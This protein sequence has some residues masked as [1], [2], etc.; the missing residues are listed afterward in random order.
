MFAAP[1]IGHFLTTGNGP[2]D[3]VVHNNEESSVSAS[4]PPHIATALEAVKR[5]LG[6]TTNQIPH[7]LAQS[8]S[9]DIASAITRHR[10]S[11][12][13]VNS[14]HSLDLEAPDIERVT[15][16]ALAHTHAA[17]Q[18]VGHTI[19]VVGI[20]EAAAIDFL[21]I[22]GIALGA[23]S[24]TPAGRGAGDVDVLV[25]PRDVPRVH[26]VLR[27]HDFRP[28]LAL[29]DVTKPRTWRVWSF[30]DREA[31][32][33]G[34]SA[35]IDLHWRISSQ[36]HLFPPFND[37]FARRTRV[38][39]AG[40]QVPTLSLAD[41]LAAAC[42]H[43]YFD[44]FQ[45]LR[46]L[47]D[48]VS[49]VK[50]SDALTLPTYSLKLQRLIAGVLD[51]TKSQLP[52]VADKE[53][54]HLMEQLATPHPLVTKR[55]EHALTTPK[56]LWEEDQDTKA[57]VAKMRAEAPFDSVID[58]LPRFVGKRL[59]HFPAWRDSHPHTTL[60]AALRNRIRVETKRRNVSK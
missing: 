59:F 23:L 27:A 20:L 1:C 11:R 19:H 5:A 17:F 48:V 28:A 36:R 45:P 6:A 4:T 49:L 42:Y 37:L 53:I 52:G 51:L 24:Q 32:Y 46:S 30:L 18:L 7:V 44:Q 12:L 13:V 38:T 54:N 9:S 16:D 56:V 35:H 34:H 41:S 58:I 21:I 39:V 47:P 22:K 31:S 26:Q 8:T 10:I 40:T 3:V 33:L 25:A 60:T 43:A 57:L 15:Q 14:G 50:A 29:P 2:N 55:F